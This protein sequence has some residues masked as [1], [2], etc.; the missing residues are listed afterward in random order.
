MERVC[1]TCTVGRAEA[2]ER[3]RKG[4]ARCHG[5]VVLSERLLNHA[6]SDSS[7]LAATHKSIPKAFENESLA[8]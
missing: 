7:D 1:L 6:L 2:T 4:S 3:L 8:V 5:N